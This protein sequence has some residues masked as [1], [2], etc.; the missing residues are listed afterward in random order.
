MR[1]RTKGLLFFIFLLLP[2]LSGCQAVILSTKPA[3]EEEG[4]LYV[5]M[6]SFPP[7]GE[8]LKFSL[9]G[10]FAVREDERSFPLSP[11][12][13]EMTPDIM[14][15]QHLLAA[16]PLP[17]GRYVGIAFEVKNAFLKSEEGYSRLLTADAPVQNNFR[18]E[19]KRKRALAVSLALKPSDSVQEGF[20]FVPAFSFALPPKP[21]LA[22]TGYVSNSRDNN[23]T[24]F[25]KKSG[26]VG[27]VIATGKNPTGMAIDQARRQAYV[28]LTEEDAIDVIDMQAGEVVNRIGL[29]SRDAPQEIALSPDGR[30]LLAISKDSDILSVIEPLSLTEESRI[31]VGNG[32]AAIAIDRNGQRA[33]VFNSLSNSLSVID[34]PSRTVVATVATDP[35]PLRGEFNGRGDKLYIAHEWSSYLT[36]L[37]TSSLSLVK[38]A[39]IGQGIS[40]MKLDTRTDMLYTSRK[41]S[42]TVEGYDPFS[43][44]PADY[45]N[46]GGEVSHMAI[47]REEGNFFFV[48]PGNGIIR[49][50]H[51]TSKEIVFEIDTGEAPYRVTMMGER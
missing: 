17:P 29:Q 27:G 33:Y 45:F 50:V 15:R 49:A 36:V 43:L 47:D 2:L 39:Y 26:R 44:L 3:L 5:Y 28:A 20:R 30:T 10:I 11:S 35:A 22:L 24:V 38:R 1:G 6:D 7:S 51:P 18:F 13:T 14:K 34:I 16:G 4:E 37:D 8:R 31:T 46:L 40:Y 48:L 32:P 19:I 9:T 12:R 25:D 23:I 21:L 42:S 41:S